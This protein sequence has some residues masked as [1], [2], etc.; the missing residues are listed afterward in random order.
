MGMGGMGNSASR[1]HGL[2]RLDRADNAILVGGIDLS[3]PYL[4]EI[5]HR[6]LCEMYTDMYMHDPIAGG[7]VDLM[8]NLPFSNFEL[9]IPAEKDSD[10]IEEVFR[11]NLNRL[12]INVLLP[13]AAREHMVYG[14][15]VSM[16]LYKASERIFTDLMS[17]PYKECIVISNP[18]YGRDSII[19]VTVTPEITQ[20]F[21]ERSAVAESMKD[22]I[23]PDMLQTIRSGVMELDPIST[24]YFPRKSFSTSDVGVSMYHRIIPI[25]LLEK[26][27]YRGTVTLA[28]RRQ[29]ALKHISGGSEDWEP[30]SDELQQ[31]I[32]ALIQAERD[33]IGAVIATRQDVEINEIAS[34]GDFWKWNDVADELNARKMLAFGINESFMQG[35]ISYAN[36]DTAL[37][38]FLEYL[39]AFRQQTTNQFFYNKLFPLIAA[40]NGFTVEEYGYKAREDEEGAVETAFDRRSGR[41]ST[42]NAGL[43]WEMGDQDAYVIP[44]IEW[45]KP[46]A[47]QGNEELLNMME[48]LSERGV[49][50]SLRAWAAA[51]GYDLK[52]LV[53][54]GYADV[55]IEKD[56][57]KMEA[58]RKEQLGDSGDE[59]DD[60]GYG[61]FASA[62]G[63]PEVGLA[64]RDYG[65]HYDLHGRTATGKK[66]WLPNQDRLHREANETVAMA[67]ERMDRKAR[68]MTKSYPP[69][70]AKEKRNV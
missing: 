45:E 6:Q 13:A 69:K 15:H 1:G 19:R 31:L 22:R 14:A 57:A 44:R 66:K 5:P 63:L 70:P 8:S 64:N 55:K 4:E 37:S 11:E 24:I 53:R 18:L 21:N 50:L 59:D 56:L 30:T 67:L 36:L 48:T 35:D 58:F 12:S 52:A 9:M 2:T 68:G 38:V 40:V 7:A 26:V 62:G 51:G 3:T 49:P 60:D 54:Q 46:L 20:F 42:F 32:Y 34:G 47:P 65:D 39:K 27:L 29:A 16:L 43:D 61:R 23:N 17:F 28:N 41:W 33:P 25:Y 10:R